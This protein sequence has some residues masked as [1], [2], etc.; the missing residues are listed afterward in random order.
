MSQTAYATYPPAPLVAQPQIDTLGSIGTNKPAIAPAMQRLIADIEREHIS[1]RQPLDAAH[2]VA[3]L[4]KRYLLEADLL[5]PEQC[6]ANPRRYVVHETYDDPGGDFL[7]RV[8]T[9]FPRTATPI[10]DHSSWCVSGIYRGYEREMQYGLAHLEAEGGQQ[11]VLIPVSS[12][13][14]GPGDVE[15]LLPPG[16]IHMVMNTGTEIALSI[17]I[18]GADIRDMAM[19]GGRIY[20]L[21][22]VA[23]RPQLQGALS[24]AR[25]YGRALRASFSPN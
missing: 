24:D 7:I 21:P 16:D 23:E 10:H 5:L 8:L 17:H 13:I 3:G 19:P 4:L 25:S 18:Y 22:I 2:R 9:W 12:N 1:K 20:D 14:R 15:A 6:I 11:E